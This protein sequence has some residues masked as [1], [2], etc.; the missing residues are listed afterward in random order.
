ML[1]FV[2]V[3]LALLMAP[4]AQAADCEVPPLPQSDKS[5]QTSAAANALRATNP[6]KVVPGLSAK[7]L[8]AVWAGLLSNKKTG[9]RRLDNA[10]PDGLPNG[11]VLPGAAGVHFDFRDVA[12]EGIRS[13]R[14][15]AGTQQLFKGT[16]PPAELDVALGRSGPGNVYTWT[17]VTRD[18]SYHG[19]FTLIEG[20]ERREVEQQLALLERSQL[21]AVSMLLYKAAILD[22]ANLYSE[23]DRVYMQLRKLIAL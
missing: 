15:E 22:D 21:D 11:S 10:V 7:S 16:V 14:L 1:K 5:A 8:K 23:R 13:F 18:N 12:S 19:E 4:A 2:P 6:C 3:L 17:L 9:G 20:D